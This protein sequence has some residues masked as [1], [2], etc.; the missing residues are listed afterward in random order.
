MGSVVELAPVAFQE[1]MYGRR[2][3]D[4]GFVLHDD[5]TVG[6]RIGKDYDRTRDLIIDPVL[7]FSTYSGSLSDNWG[8]TATYDLEGN[9]YAAGM[10]SGPGYPATI[11]AYDTIYNNGTG[12][13]PTDIA[14]SKYSPD[15]TELIFATYL[16]GSLNEIPHSIITNDQNELIIYGTTGSSDYP[17]TV[18]AYDIS[19]G[20]GPP[21]FPP[22][23]I[24]YAQGSDIVI[25][26]LNEA[27]TNLLGST[28]FG[29]SLNDGL[30]VTSSGS[31][32]Y[33]YGDFARGDVTV[34]EN[35]DIIIASCTFSD[36]IATGPGSF[37]PDKDDGLGGLIAR[38]SP[39]L[40][41]LAWATYLGGSGD[42]AAYSIEPDGDDLI[43]GGGTAS[44][45]MPGM[46]GHMT[47]YNGGQADG[48]LFR[49]S[50]DGSTSSGG[51]YL[52]TNAYDQ[53]YFVDLDRDGGVYAYGQ[54]LGD[55]PVSAG[56]YSVENAA[57]FIHKFNST[58]TDS[59]LS[60]VFGSS[61]P[62]V[63]AKRVNISPTAFLV[64]NCNNIYCIGWGGSVNNGYNPA[65]GNTF[66]MD[67]TG[68]AFSDSTDGS[69]FYLAVLEGGADDLLFA[70]YFGEFGGRGDHV[71]GGTSRFDKNGFVY[72][73]SCASCGGT[74]GFPTTD[75]AW[76]EI[77]GSFNCNMGSFKI[78]FDFAP[79]EAETN[80]DPVSGCPPLEVAFTNNSNLDAEYYFWDFGDG[81]TSG[82][83]NPEHVF[84]EIGVYDIQ[85]IVIDSSNCVIADTAY[86]QV[87]VT[88]S[89]NTVM[90]AFDLSDTIC[91]RSNTAFVNQSE[92]AANYLWDFGDGTTSEETDPIHTYI[93]E[94]TY[95]VTLI[96]DPGSFCSDTATRE[97]MVLENE[98]FPLFEFSQP[99]CTD[100]AAIIQFTDATVSDLQIASW[101]WDFGDGTTSG[102]QDP[103]HE[104]PA[105]GDYNVLLQVTDVAGCLA[106]TVADIS[107]S[108][109]PF[110]ADFEVRPNCDPF[111]FGTQFLDIS[112]SGT[113]V[114]S[115]SW[116]FGDGNISALQDPLHFYAS[117]GVYDVTLIA[118]DEF[119]CTDTVMQQ[120]EIFEVALEASFTTAPLACNDPVVT[121]INTTASDT[122]LEWFWNFGDGNTSNEAN[123]V[124]EY[125]AAG[126]YIVTLTAIHP[127]GCV[128]IL[129]QSVVLPVLDVDFTIDVP[130]GC[131]N[132]NVPIVF[133]ISGITSS[134]ITGAEWDFGDG[135]VTPGFSTV[136]IYTEP[137]DYTVQYVISNLDGCID[138]TRHPLTI[139]DDLVADAGY[140]FDVCSADEL[141]VDFS[142]EV[143][144][145]SDIT[146]ISWDFGDG[147]G[148][149]GEINP[150]HLY[151]SSGTYTVTVMVETAEGCTGSDT[152]EVEVFA[153]DVS[154]DFLF[155]DPPC[156]T[157]EVAFMNNTVS[158]DSIVSWLWDFGDGASSGLENP[159]HIF[160]GPGEYE[161]NLTALSAAG[162]T[163]SFS[164]VV[165]VT[166]V[167]LAG[168]D[169]LAICSGESVLLP[170]T[171]NFGET[172][173]W[174]PPEPLNDPGI[175][176]PLASPAET[177]EF[178]VTVEDI[179]G[180]QSCIQYDTVVVE[181]LEASAVEA[182]AEQY[183]V[184]EGETTVLSAT[185]GFD[186][187]NWDPATNLDDPSSQQV[188][189]TVFDDITYEVTAT[190]ENGCTSTDTVNLVVL[191]VEECQLET[192][193]IPTAFSPNGDGRND[194]F[195]ITL[196]GAYDI[197]ELQVYDRW[198]EKI[199]E[200]DDAGEG[201][202]G[203]YDGKLLA[204]DA[205]GY[206]LTIYCNGESISRKGNVTLVR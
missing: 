88:D 19:F 16:G 177:T 106:F 104:F 90:A 205:F 173:S 9:L 141:M 102:E 7:V 49:L 33:N 41:Q 193:F 4:A 26:R 52:G 150:S 36:D 6:F 14:I 169:S 154:V 8:F 39:D 40:S 47:A 122:T 135:T 198:G 200:T 159:V 143:S 147:N 155:G 171:A 126:S 35:G 113:N 117:P 3:V 130:P 201:W 5:G 131:S 83:E 188:L 206:L 125:A 59:E 153:E 123:P 11:G 189:A 27:G 149:A 87:T 166:Q 142:L 15:G 144:P 195:R 18:N 176:Q 187:Y 137:G 184:E 138:T 127:S 118:T 178:V 63:S 58:L 53:V 64:D 129:N 70:T 79:L 22:S 38:F 185:P 42:D 86:T 128:T 62:S 99:N 76:S 202:D 51:T 17:V 71:D 37:Q 81:T 110:V 32:E 192:L 77:N 60:T 94:G 43:V 116:D 172:I 55:Y 190:D 164:D 44:E 54:T 45:D 72:H 50:G 165:V 197:F 160:P 57:Q 103:L 124:H 69:D 48:F 105:S 96:A 199:F 175:L 191:D 148:V 67:V 92:N 74:Q 2:S 119:G 93:T 101:Q 196:E 65:T 181:V 109:I 46:T 68:D 20:G 30:N 111:T 204:T 161:V 194:L 91:L 121:F 115:W 66:D 21:A 97:I 25:T 152:I 136:H 107:V 146:N 203:R 56:I 95:T 134:G 180:G 10:V 182:S 114:I 179:I 28:F 12:F 75:S 140:A 163:Y 34:A 89:L 170:F 162:C 151:S 158:E 61:W 24:E 133:N 98:L 174:D 78:Q 186:T 112:G 29:G 157:R 167:E 73:G 100:S 108:A 80:A 1:T 85:F 168:P 183:E 84:T 139:G 132:L 156:N 145:P 82:E 13:V 120:A 31:L 23:N